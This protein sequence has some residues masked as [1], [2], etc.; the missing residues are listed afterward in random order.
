M[1]QR[2]LVWDFPT[3]VFHWLLAASFAGAWYISESDEWL[4]FH[5]F[6]G[7]LMLGLIYFRVIWGMVGGH[8][9]RFTSFLYC[10]AA[11]LR[12][13]RE[14][15]SGRGER[16]IGHNPAGSQAIFLLL[17]L[18]LAVCLTG[19][20][21][22]GAE[23]HQGPLAGWSGVTSGAIVREAHGIIAVVMLLIVIGHIAGV[24]M[25]SRLH[26][27]NLARSMVTGIKEAPE[28]LPAS[29][30][31]RAAGWLLLVTAIAF[32]V[33]WFSYA[34][35]HEPVEQIVGHEEAIEGPHIAFVGPKLPDN[36]TW[37]EEC[38]SCHLAF[39]PN[40]L[41]ARS[42]EKLMA[43][44]D[45]HFGTDLALDEATR[46][47]VLAFLVNNAAEKSDREAAF[48]INRSIK[49]GDTP[50]RITETPYWINKHREV[51]DSVWKSPEV[52][53]KA[54]CAAC[55]MDADAGTFEDSAMQIPR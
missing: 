4:S 46:K 8:Y 32:G 23:E 14:S 52:K 49:P 19:I 26:K 5:A 43:E 2:I 11:G 3:R 24:V 35:W 28:G 47:E 13:L 48:K 31:Y 41:P 36:V 25:E 6:F 50:L 45:K 1:S 34:S 44:Q 10:P 21:A 18:G 40:L 20:F 54:N 38:G 22:Q 55:H 51:E 9:A 15:L 12:Y 33:W 30:P 29:K 7:Y 53:S 39:H 16:Y 17:G 42:W 37:R 27:E